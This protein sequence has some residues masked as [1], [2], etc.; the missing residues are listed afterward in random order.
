MAVSLYLSP[1]PSVNGLFRNA[2]AANGKTI[3]VKTK[4]YTAW[5]EE[6]MYRA[7]S[8]KAACFSFGELAVCDYSV[9]IRVVRLEKRR[10]LDNYVKP[11]LDML[12]KAGI[13]R[14]D[15]YVKRIIVEYVDVPKT[16]APPLERQVWVHVTPGSIQ[17]PSQ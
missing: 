6:S 10:D 5:L 13:I 9:H 16:D 2:R 8:A 15:R 11:I 12:V 14:D 3:R 7:N 4:E 1:P 17:A